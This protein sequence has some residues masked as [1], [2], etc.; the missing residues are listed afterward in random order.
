MALRIALAKEM[1]RRGM[2]FEQIRRACEP[3]PKDFALLKAE[4]EAEEDDF[5]EAEWVEDRPEPARKKPKTL[6]YA[7]LSLLFVS[8]ALTLWVILLL[9]GI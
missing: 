7:S 1:A 5:I 8:T 9:F 2:P 3:T 6:Y 4:I